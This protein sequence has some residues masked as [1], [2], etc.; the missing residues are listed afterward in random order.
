[1]RGKLALWMT[2]A[3]AAA[4]VLAAFVML[5]L[6][7]GVRGTDAALAATARLSFLLF[8]PSYAGG[9]MA[10]LFGSAF[11]PLRQHGRTFGLTF[12]A[13][14]LVHLGLV[15]WLCYIGA[16]PSTGTFVV[17]GIAVG[18]IYLLAVFSF[19]PTHRLLNAQS[20]WLLRTLGLNYIAYAF[21]IDFL[22]HPFSG[23][24]RHMVEYVPFALLAVLGPAVRLAA[25]A[26]RLARPAWAPTQART[27]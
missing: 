27:F 22:R 15:G 17:F 16:V 5:V 19:Q 10:S 7:T 14:H 2:L 8:W 23:G 9:A 6:G 3:F 25:F 12:A 26:R 21:A 18:W 4:L 20:W 24:L 11:Q 13:A 1:M